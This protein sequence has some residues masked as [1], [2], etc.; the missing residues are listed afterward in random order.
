MADDYAGVGLAAASQ[1]PTI[2]SAMDRFSKLISF[3]QSAV[4][5]A[6]ELAARLSG[7]P[8]PVTVAADKAQTLPAGSTAALND[9]ASQLEALFARLASNVS[10]A[11]KAHG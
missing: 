11:L 5:T 10:M 9:M 7:S 6:E 2:G 1:Q 3:G 4:A 8:A